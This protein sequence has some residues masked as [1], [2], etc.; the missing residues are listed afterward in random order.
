MKIGYVNIK[1]YLRKTCKYGLYIPWSNLLLTYGRSRL[2]E[3]Y[4]QQICANRNRK[5][6]QILQPV[7]D[8]ALKQANLPMEKV[9]N[10][11]IWVCWFQGESQMPEIPKMCLASIRKNANGHPVILLTDENYDQY[12][13]M[14]DIVLQRFQMGQL[15]PAHFADI[16]RIHLLAQQGG[17]WLD[18][19]LLLTSPL[20][21]EIFSA[22]LFTIKTKP[23]GCFVS[24]CRWTVFCLASWKHNPLFVK[25]AKSFELYLQETDIFVDYFMFDQ[26][27]DMLYQRDTTIRAMLDAVPFNNEHVHQLGKV[28]DKPYH[29]EH[30]TQMSKDTYLFKLS[31]KAFQTGLLNATSD[32]YYAHLKQQFQ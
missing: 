28:L 31:W 18:A 4:K 2:S 16:L 17:I 19:T 27:V 24:Q 20:P 22:P 5:I 32:S 8:K 3:S 7:V 15:K 30:W 6:Q 10:A 11:P 9:S 26:F 12:V 21:E 23:F 29:P 14:P 1:N 13:H 25:L